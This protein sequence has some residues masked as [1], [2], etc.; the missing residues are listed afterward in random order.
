[1][2]FKC[3]IASAAMAVALAPSMAAADTI[4][5][6]EGARAKER[7]GRWLDSQDREQLRRWGG[8]DDYARYRYG[9]YD[10]GYGDGYDHGPIYYY[11]AYPY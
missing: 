6:V 4:E 2:M 3:L 11:R 9:R 8:N 5:S 7:Q 10:R 1:M